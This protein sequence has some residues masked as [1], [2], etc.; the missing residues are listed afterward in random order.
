MFVILF[1]LYLFT[2]IAEAQVIQCDCSR[3]FVG[4]RLDLV[5]APG[6]QRYPVADVDPVTGNYFLLWHSTEPT[7]SRVAGR[8]YSKTGAPLYSEFTFESRQLDGL[9]VGSPIAVVYNSRVAAFYIAWVAYLF[10]ATG[11]FTGSELRSTLIASNGALLRPP[12][13]SLSVPFG[14]VVHQILYNRFINGYVLLYS[15]NLPNH[16]DVLYGQRLNSAGQD[17]GNPVRISSGLT[18]INKAEIRLDAIRNRYAV[19]WTFSNSKTDQRAILVQVLTSKLQKIGT[20]L[21]VADLYSFPHA[22]FN[23]KKK[24]FVIFWND[25]QKPFARLILPNGTFGSPAI[26]LNV[27][28]FFTAT[29]TNPQD[30]GFLI[31]R[32]KTP[33]V[34]RLD[35]DFNVLEKTIYATCQSG[36]RNNPNL[37]IY[38]PVAKEF[39][40]VWTY[41][42]WARDGGMEIHGRR[43]KAI[44]SGSLCK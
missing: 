16:W 41:S 6:N 30:D 22:V 40:V 42:Y 1:L 35:N 26:P 19:S 14:T 36:D 39:L 21:K 43:M 10:D 17:L 27:S 44:P 7:I 8:I 2:N 25:Q 24:A 20:V 38:N 37:L 34:A 23:G 28:G 3:E 31:L 12:Q 11:T 29:K 15:L 33:K 5:I 32:G 9:S 13:K 4:D 18:R